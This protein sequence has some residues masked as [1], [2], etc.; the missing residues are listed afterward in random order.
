MKK[1]TGAMRMLA[2]FVSVGA[3]GAIAYILLS[4]FLVTLGAQAWIASVLCYAALIP[5]VYVGQRSLTFRS[6]AAVSSSFLKY[7][8]TQLFGLGLSAA[9]PYVIERNTNWSPT[10]AF[11]YVAVLTVFV[12]FMLLKFW[13]FRDTKP[14]DRIGSL[15]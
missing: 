2:S 10:T 6:K 14:D 12:N 15:D 1:L 11:F 13:A 4:S 8:A 7:A 3:A 9:L 5:V